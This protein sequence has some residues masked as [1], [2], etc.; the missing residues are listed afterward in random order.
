MPCPPGNTVVHELRRLAVLTALAVG[1]MARAAGAQQIES[2]LPGANNFINAVA[3]VGNTLYLGGTFS[4]VGLSTGAFVAL[5]PTTGAPAPPFFNVSVNG[6]QAV[7]AAV[8][9]GSGGW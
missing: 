3:R 8:S 7:Y 5:D 2:A 4:Y 9:D 1:A 6:S